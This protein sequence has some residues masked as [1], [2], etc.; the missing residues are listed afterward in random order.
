M[1][2]MPFRCDNTLQERSGLNY[3]AYTIFCILLL[4]LIGLRITHDLEANMDVLLWDEANYLNRGLWMFHRIPKVWGPSYSAW[5]KFVSYIQPEKI[6][7][8]YLNYRIM[9]IGTAVVGFLFLASCG[10]RQWIAFLLC[11][12]LL[13]S[14]YNLP[15]WPKI[16][17]YCILLVMLAILISKYLEDVLAKWCVF[18]L[19]LL[20]CAYARPEL[21]LSF[22]LCFLIT[23]LQAVWK[24]KKSK[25]STRIFF[26]LTV[27]WVGFICWQYKTP[28]N[29]GDSGRSIKVFYQHFAMN[30]VQWNHLKLNWWLVWPDIIQKNFQHPESISSIIK[31]NGHLF[32]RHI[33]SNLKNYFIWMG[34]LAGQFFIPFILKSY[35]LAILGVL[36]MLLYFVASG[37]KNFRSNLISAIHENCRVLFFL[38]LFIL[39]GI[40]VCVYAYPREHYL[41]INIPLLLLIFGIILSAIQNTDDSWK[42]WLA[43]ALGIIFFICAPKAGQFDF[44]QLERQE[45]S[46]ANVQTLKYLQQ[47]DPA[48]TLRILDLEGDLSSLLSGKYKGYTNAYLQQQ[49]AS[50]VDFMDKNHI[51]VVYITPVLLSY[52]L[53]QH[54]TAFQE[55]LKYPDQHQFYAEK[56]GNFTPY[57]LSRKS[58][59]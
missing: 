52:S 45:K 14:S 7:L 59:K 30:Y 51:D 15:V 26:T 28:F 24:F 37:L 42:K 39:P 36:S 41:V 1:K 10:V 56:T 46:L 34:S 20:A 57:L 13:L 17:H 4:I 43:L 35:C 9:T 49:P 12:C 22:S 19:A 40:L 55:L 32:W 54:D 18:S 58:Y 48:D 3:S 8:Y 53:V 44:Y 6:P 31:Y 11:C 33:F 29:S 38:L 21:F 23:L 50:V 47:I 25:I 16:S 5:Y 27:F 2:R